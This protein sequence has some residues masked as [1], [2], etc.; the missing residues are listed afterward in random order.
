MYERR[1]IEV[2]IDGVLMDIINTARELGGFTQLPSP[3]LPKD[4]AMTDAGELR[5]PLLA[6]A[7]TPEIVS[8]CQLLEEAY[9][10]LKGLYDKL[11]HSR[12]TV[13]I[14]GLMFSEDCA[15][16]R[17]PNIFPILRDID[18][19]GEFFSLTFCI[20]NDIDAKQI[21]DSAYVYV[22]DYSL[23]LARSS[24]TYKVL[25]DRSYNQ[26]Y[27]NPELEAL[28]YH[29]VFSLADCLNYIVEVCA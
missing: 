5:K 12:Y 20:G 17:R 1:R 11:D 13:D 22:E 14:R 18:K 6:C 15:T 19:D 23:N 25:R 8:K 26:E 27:N 9:D 7:T 29:R 21:T 2:D 3:Y 16:A 28:D 4:Y 24:A 10:F